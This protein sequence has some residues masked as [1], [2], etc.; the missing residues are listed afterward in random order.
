MQINVEIPESGILH[1]YTEEIICE[2][3]MKW[4]YTELYLF[5]V[6]LEGIGRVS[7]N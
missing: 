6:E 3:I 4:N 5:D 1:T 2:L 7:E